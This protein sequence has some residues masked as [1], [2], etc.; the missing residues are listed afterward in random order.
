M[1]VE[2]SEV[3]MSDPVRNPP[4]GWSL[5]WSDEFDGPAGSAPDPATWQAEV[6]G[7]GWGN[8]ELQ[9]YTNG[10]DNAAL[11]GASNLAIM[12]R[13]S[14]PLV[15]DCRFAGC[16]YTSARLISKD[17]LT[18]C[19]GLVQAR[20]RLPGG[21]GIWPAFWM[22]GDDIDEVGWPRCGEIDVMEN[23]GTDPA[24]VH[25]T[26]HGPGYSGRGGVTASYTAPASLADDFHV[27]SV[28]WE[29]DRIRWYLDDELYGTVTH[30]DLRGN[31]WV[32]DHAFFLLL[33]VAV[34]GAFSQAP[35]G[36]VPF[37]QTMLIDYVR[38]F[39]PPQVE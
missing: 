1:G 2:R 14:D 7:H 36:S 34:G 23:F 31:P 37:P 11:D 20:M 22:L 35:D 19:H 10:S 33:N 16:E 15:R 24:V 12:V 13:R 28:R 27:Y 8:E 5:T 17:R 25:G 32:F 38:R 26:V 4:P 29:P 9:Y 18:V 39:E 21:R 6:G 30:A 3:L